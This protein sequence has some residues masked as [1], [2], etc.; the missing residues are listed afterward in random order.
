MKKN[1]IKK[2]TS[3]VIA[4]M[5]ATAMGASALA[6]DLEDGE[7]GGFTTPDTA[8]AQDKNVNIQK[9]ITAYNPDGKNVYGPAITYTYAIAPAAGDELVNI[10]DETTDHASGVAVTAKANAGITTGVTMAGTSANTI[11]WTNADI[12]ET[13]ATGVANIKNLNVDFSNVVFSQ[14]GVFRYK[15]TET[16]E[17]YVTSGVE[18][19]D[20]TNVRY[21]DVYVKRAD[22]YTTGDTAAQWE[23]YGYVCVDSSLGTTD[24]TPETVKTNGFVDSDT[25][26]DNSTADEYRTYNLTVTKTLVGDDSMLNNEFPFDVAF[27][28]GDATG[29]FQLAAE[30]TGNA[31]V[32]T[33]SNA[34][35]TTVPGSAVAAG[36]LLKSGA[37]D[38]LATAGKD[39]NPTIANGATVTYVGIPNGT[40]VTVTETNNVT[41]T[42]YSTT[43]TQKVGDADAAAVEFDA[44]STGA[45]S[46][47]SK[48]VSVDNQETAVYAQAAATADDTDVTIAFTNT[49]AVISPTGVVVR[50]APYIIMIAAAGVL[51][52]VAFKTKRK[53][54]E[55]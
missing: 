27:D 17:A 30:S 2:A 35:G 32:T 16:A 10:T 46:S 47:D 20:N 4:T 26:T 29:T 34:A 40:T 9:E 28:N 43:A 53:A 19:G 37:A 7:V 36:S 54:D 55:A 39:G 5:V 14:P 13:S 51:A 31:T 1:I 52:V 48:T 45:L 41:G 42:T 18:D 3:V 21:L 44:S 49:F 23:I 22:S 15:I 38:A 6:T 33:T 24:I 50:Y 8:V 25:A 12:L 11:A